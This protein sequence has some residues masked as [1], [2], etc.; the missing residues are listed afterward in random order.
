MLLLQKKQKNKTKNKG[1]C[2]HCVREGHLVSH[3]ISKHALKSSQQFYSWICQI[4]LALDSSAWS[5]NLVSS[6][7]LPVTKGH[8]WHIDYLSVI[9]FCHGQV[10][11][12]YQV[13]QAAELC[14]FKRWTA[15]WSVT[16]LSLWENLIYTGKGLPSKHKQLT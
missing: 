7:S 11:C 13:L 9:L 6:C 8:N 1:S 3:H 14:S 12:T 10:G 16:I 5:T 2:I 15:V 4:Q